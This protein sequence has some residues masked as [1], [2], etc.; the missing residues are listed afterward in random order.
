M[1]L[2]MSILHSEFQSMCLIRSEMNDA[3]ERALKN[4]N[5]IAQLRDDN[6]YGDCQRH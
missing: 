2:I 4:C 5:S 6:H 1:E 3:A